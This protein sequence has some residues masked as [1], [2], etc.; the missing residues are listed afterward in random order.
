MKLLCL[1]YSSLSF[2]LEGDR[3]LAF[4]HIGVNEF[5]PILCLFVSLFESLGAKDLEIFLSY[6][7]G[8]SPSGLWNALKFRA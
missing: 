6:L 4:F 3:I 8:R 5:V 2:L 7:L 1:P